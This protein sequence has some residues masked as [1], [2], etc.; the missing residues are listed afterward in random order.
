[1]NP[2]PPV[3]KMALMNETYPLSLRELTAVHDIELHRKEIV[4]VFV[5]WRRE[6]FPAM[7]WRGQ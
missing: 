6:M 4:Q 5:R 3:T 7:Q 1:M 2:D